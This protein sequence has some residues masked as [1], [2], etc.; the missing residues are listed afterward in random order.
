MLAWQRV[1]P[2]V[3]GP[4]VAG[5]RS[6]V[7]QLFPDRRGVISRQLSRALAAKDP[8]LVAPG[9][10]E[11]KSVALTGFPA[12]EQILYDDERLPAPGRSTPDADY[13]CALAAAIAGNRPSGANAPWP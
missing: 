10:L 6:S 7:I 5:A 13:A 12:L 4:I 9:E 1:Q 11:G 8:A 2:V 3:F